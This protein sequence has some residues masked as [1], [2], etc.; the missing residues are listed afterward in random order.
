MIHDSFKKVNPLSSSRRSGARRRRHRCGPAATHPGHCDTSAALTIAHGFC[1]TQPRG[2]DR[3]G[4]FIGS[5]LAFRRHG[6]S[7]G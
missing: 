4:R 5:E 6:P 3:R 1:A 2:S 7:L